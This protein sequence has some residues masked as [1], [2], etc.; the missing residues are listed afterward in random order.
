MVLLIMNINVEVNNIIKLVIMIYIICYKENT[1]Y[2][3][4]VMM[5]YRYP[6]LDVCFIINDY[7]LCVIITNL[8]FKKVS[9]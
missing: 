4:I 8:N 9:L 5:L 6:L 2:H 1:S 7:Y 3:A